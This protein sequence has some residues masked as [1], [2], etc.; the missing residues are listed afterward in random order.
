MGVRVMI[1][2]KT[3]RGFERIDFGDWNDKPCSLQQSSAILD[4]YPDAFDR[5]GSSAVWLGR[6][7]GRAHLSR[8]QVAE[9]VRHLTAWLEVL[10]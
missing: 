4:H 3:D 7:D 10:Q 2:T 9:L 5:P 1:V 8:E 6:D